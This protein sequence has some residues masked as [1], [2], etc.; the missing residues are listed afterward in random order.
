MAAL[1]GGLAWRLALAALVVVVLWALAW[2][3]RRAARRTLRRTPALASA[4]VLIDRSL[5]IGFLLLAVSWVFS[6]FG[7]QLTALVAILGAVGLAVSLSLQDLLRNLVAGVFI[8]VEH[9]FVTGDLIDFRTFSGV[10]ERIDLR[11]TILRAP[12]GQRVVIPNA[13]LFSEALVNRS[14]SGRQLVRLRVVVPPG[15]PGDGGRL[16]ERTLD[17]LR[18]AAGEA[19]P[20]PAARPYEPAWPGPEP[21]PAVLVESLGAEKAVLLAEVWATDARA[22]APRLAWALRQRLPEADIIVLD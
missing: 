16:E 9:P 5:Q 2:L 6:V 20:L 12:G 15:E 10:V 4:A 1:A 14:A 22:A 3:A 17:A 11:T 19:I 7:V 8:L 21:G 13:M 18:G